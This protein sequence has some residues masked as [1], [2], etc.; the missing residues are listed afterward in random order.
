MPRLVNPGKHEVE[1]ISGQHHRLIPVT[2]GEGESRNVVLLMPEAESNEAPAAKTNWAPDPWVLGGFTTAAV[3]GVLGSVAG[4]LAWSERKKLDDTCPDRV[5]PNQEMDRLDRAHRYANVSTYAF[6]VGGIG[7]AVGI[8]ALLS[9]GRQDR[10]DVV[11]RV[12]PAGG[13]LQVAGTF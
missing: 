1:V 9:D 6:I 8:G 3:G 13:A 11:V 2:V 10:T 5:C 4:G 12:N 7:A